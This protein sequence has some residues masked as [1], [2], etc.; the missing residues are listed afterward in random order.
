MIHARDGNVADSEPN[1][2]KHFPNTANTYYFEEKNIS[3]AL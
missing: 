2:G 1:C 3:S